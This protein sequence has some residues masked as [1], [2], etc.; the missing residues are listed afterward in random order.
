MR[1]LVYVNLLG[2]VGLAALCGF[3]WEA[4]RKANL[5]AESLDKTRQEQDNQIMRQ[6]REIAGYAE[7]LHEAQDHI[8]TLRDQRD[9]ATAE[10]NSAAAAR[11]QAIAE[12]DQLKAEQEQSKEILAKWVSAVTQR[13]DVIKKAFARIEDLAKERNDKITE[14][15]NVIVKYNALAKQTTKAAPAH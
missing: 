13:D 14:L 7:D 15:N 5:L 10:R 6:K 1:Y 11:D 12:R 8:A 4:N 3:Q 9:K 2:V